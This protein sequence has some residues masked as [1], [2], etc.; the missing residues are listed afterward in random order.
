MVDEAL[1]LGLIDRPHEQ[2]V[3]GEDP[4]PGRQLTLLGE[5]A[6]IEG[7]EG[8]VDSRGQGSRHGGKVHDGGGDHP[9]AGHDIGPK[10][11][12]VEAGFGEEH[13]VKDL[14]AR[15][16]TGRLEMELAQALAAV[17]LVANKELLTI[18]AAADRLQGWIDC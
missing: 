5:G 7:F 8:S 11:R 17:H 16:Q 9:A 1:L 3:A 10:N 2:H 14:Q 13:A 15:P 4:A 18:E 6:G 12:Q